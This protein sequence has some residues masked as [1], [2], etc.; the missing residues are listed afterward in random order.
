M[1]DREARLVG[2][3]RTILAAGSLLIATGSSYGDAPAHVRRLPPPGYSIGPVQ[4]APAYGS[5]DGRRLR[6]LPVAAGERRHRQPY[7]DAFGGLFRFP[8]VSTNGLQ[9]P[10]FQPDRAFRRLPA[11]TVEANESFPSLHGQWRTRLPAIPLTDSPSHTVSFPRCAAPQDALPDSW[12]PEDAPSRAVQPDS[13]P[14][15]QRAVSS[16]P[17]EKRLRPFPLV[18]DEAPRDPTVDSPHPPQAATP[19]RRTSRN[20]AMLAMAEHAD[21][22]TQ[23]GFV[24]ARRGAIYSARAEFISAL[25]L[26]AQTLDAKEGGKS[27]SE[28]LASGLRALREA[29]DFRVRGSQLAA[30]MDLAGI[31]AAHRT[32]VL[33]DVPLDDLT[34]LMAGQRYCGYA[35]ERL[36][37]AINNV[38]PGSKALFGLG[39][40]YLILGNGTTRAELAAQPK[41]MAAYQAAILADPRNHLASNELG[42]LLAHYGQ[43]DESFRAFSHSLSMCPTPETWHNLAVVQERVGDTTMATFSRGRAGA[44]PVRQPAAR[45]QV[46]ILWVSPEEFA[47]A[48]PEQSHYVV[49]R[50]PRTETMRPAE[51]KQKE[52]PR[53]ASATWWQ[54][55]AAAEMATGG[56]NVRLCQ[57]LAPVHGMPVG[58]PGRHRVG[59]FA[60]M[61]C[62]TG[63]FGAYRQGEYVG[64][65]RTTHV[66]EYRL[67]VD[68]QMEF[69]YRLTREESAVPY[70]LNVGDVIVVESI[71]DANINRGGIPDGQG[72]VIQPDGTIT[73]P[74]LGQVH[75]A[76]LTVTELR[77]SLNEKYKEYVRD[78]QITVT[79]LRVNTK[80]EDLRS[81]VDSRYGEGGQ[82]RRARVT[83]EGTVQL[84]AIGS[85]PA[86]GLTI[87]ELKREID[88]RYIQI[89]DGV[90]VTP[91]LS[92]RAPR[93]VYVIGEVPA[94][95]RFVLEGPTTVMQAIAMAGGWNHGGN[96]RQVIVFRR[97]EDWCLLATKV[98]IQ[99][100]LWGKSACPA[101]EIWLRDSDLVLVPKSSLL[102][103]DDLID[104]I[105]TRGIYGVL[106]VGF[107]WELARGSTL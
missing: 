55:H 101:G 50:A 56:S 6:R 51:D 84:P 5:S 67:R 25:G 104:L 99:R 27:H 26:V 7:G 94:S 42:V 44:V 60:S 93:Y 14:P 48:R 87:G 103:A 1:M 86:Q 13:S 85:V 79:P 41:A 29:D 71:T 66:P 21:S 75:A 53:S 61:P 37:T 98:D 10:S 88:E 45:D 63:T 74:M 22:L 59:R 43:F 20:S 76:R 12:Q 47:R 33:D 73:L 90:E 19:V 72:L 78:P 102:L 30:E 31:V 46:P 65:S 64:P 52:R 96:L 92:E 62:E 35:R 89:V 40:A 70:Q 81:A 83:P 28:A 106:P 58:F 34:P 82:S 95:G 80:L 3:W 32:P 49:P 39:K 36:S 16:P 9:Q 18:R 23:H 11:L 57:S 38:P 4:Q 107:G 100:A 68:D 97:T 24:L 15:E 17:A 8:P 77:K 2:R 91:I 69:V 105:F 54:Q